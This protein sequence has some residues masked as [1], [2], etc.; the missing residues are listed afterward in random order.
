MPYADVIMNWIQENIPGGTSYH[1]NNAS[2]FIQKVHDIEEN[3]WV[4]QLGIKGKVDVTLK[5]KS[6]GKTRLRPLEL[7]TGKSGPSSEHAAQVMLYNLMLSSRYK[8]T[9]GNGSLLYLKDG[10]TREVRSRALELKGIMN[11]R[12]NLA[13]YLSRLKFDLLPEPRTDPR[14]CGKCD[15]ALVCSFYQVAIEPPDRSSKLMYNFA[16]ANMGHLSESH[17]EVSAYFKKWMRWIFYEWAED[18]ARKG[19]K[20]EDLW[21]KTPE[22]R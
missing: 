19:S 6:D 21:R 5:V 17:L 14:F 15:Q 7:K 4:P 3:I 16:K 13:F 18:K 9:L 12:N 10:V 20:L 11:Q 8:Q 22:E 2:C 1:S